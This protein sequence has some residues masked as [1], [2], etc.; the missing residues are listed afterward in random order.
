MK[1]S[2][3]Y[4]KQLFLYGEG[5]DGPIRDIKRLSERSG[6]PQRTL[7]DWVQQWREESKEIAI[8]GT[9]SPF[10]VALS[11][12]TIEKHRKE[13]SFLGRQV[14]KLR[15]RL[16]K[17]TAD[18]SEYHVV[19]KSY[20]S[21]ITKWEKSSGILAH[22]DTA[23]AAMKEGARAKAREEAKRNSTPTGDGRPVPSK[24]GRFADQ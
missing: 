10:T 2:T 4:A 13:V 21:S 23:T 11:D 5:K 16:K 17:L 12:E 20:E 9:D 6:A 24:P 15:L 8:R 1:E 7:R 18:M 14:T 19:L 3:A 22:Y